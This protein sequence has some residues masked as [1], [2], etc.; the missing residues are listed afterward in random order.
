M[1]ANQLMS[2]LETGSIINSV[3]FPQ[4][5]LDAIDGYRLAVTNKNVPGMLGQMTALLA[6]REINV[7]DLINKS[8]DDVAYNLIDLAEEPDAGLVSAFAEIESVISV[9]V[10]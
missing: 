7:I 6:E 1:A 10:I 2:F 3:N 9:R 5:S 8:R 4:V